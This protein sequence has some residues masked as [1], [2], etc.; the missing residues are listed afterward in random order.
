MV[1]GS[2]DKLWMLD[3]LGCLA[4]ASISGGG[5]GNNDKSRPQ[6]YSEKLKAS[7]TM[8]SFLNR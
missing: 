5:L 6:L 3:Y 4:R 8:P 7:I 1:L 2:A